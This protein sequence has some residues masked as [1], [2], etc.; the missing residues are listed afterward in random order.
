MIRLN[1]LMQTGGIARDVESFLLNVR[2]YTICVAPKSANGLFFD[3]RNYI[4]ERKLCCRQ[5]MTF[6]DQ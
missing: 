5:A 1:R 6:R 3:P 2:N 4:A